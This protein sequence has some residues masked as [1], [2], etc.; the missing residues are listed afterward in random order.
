[1]PHSLAPLRLHYDLAAGD[2]HPLD[3]SAPCFCSFVYQQQQQQPVPQQGGDA[4]AQMQQ[5]QQGQLPMMGSQVPGQMPSADDWK[6][7]M[8]FQREEPKTDEQQTEPAPHKKALFQVMSDKV[9]ENKNGEIDT[10]KD[11]VAADNVDAKLA[12]EV[13]ANET[14][15]PATVPA[16]AAVAAPAAA[17][18]HVD[19]SA[20]DA[21]QKDWVKTCLQ[22]HADQPEKCGQKAKS[23][24]AKRLVPVHPTNFDDLCLQFHPDD[25]SKCKKKQAGAPPVVHFV[26]PAAPAVA[27][28][29]VKAVVNGT[30]GSVVPPRFQQVKQEAKQQAKHRMTTGQQRAQEWL[31][32]CQEMHGVD[33]AR[34][35]EPPRKLRW[36]PVRR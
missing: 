34:C 6:Q 29:V 17:A 18:A 11:S 14:A 19:W 31:S 3:L 20:A 15:T 21:E 25:P 12:A 23:T 24:G 33:S 36:S 28:K 30:V 8:R 27:S 32:I 26:H 9:Q 16:A 13:K 35:R 7:M 22:F 4:V 10:S 5:Q 2:T 1:M